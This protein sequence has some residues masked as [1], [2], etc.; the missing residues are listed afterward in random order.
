MRPRMNKRMVALT[1]GTGTIGKR[2]FDAHGDQPLF[3][4]KTRLE[5][6]VKEM[7]AELD[8]VV[9]PFAFLHLAAVT[10][11]QDCEKDPEHAF[12]LNVDGALKWLQAA[13]DSGCERFV[14]V[15]T[16]HVFRPTKQLDWLE[17]SRSPDATTIY[18]RSKAEAEKRLATEAS[19]LG[20]PLLIARVFSVI[21]KGMRKGFLYSEL[22][23]RAQERDFNPM[24]GYKNVRDFIEAEEAAKA[25]YS[26]ASEAELSNEKVRIAHV[27]TGVP[28]T[29]RELA[30]DVFRQ[31]GIGDEPLVAGM[32][33]ETQDDPNYLVSKPT[34]VDA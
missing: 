10:L 5:A 32:F 20:V 9:Q 19:R 30:L 28:R 26:L 34:K 12:R 25:L 6:E 8:Q 17:P 11:V 15:S 13:A 18:G 31:H 21:D 29:V 7:R 3:A 14:F 33:P 16:G 22:E 1:G 4:L 2:L 27:C 24:P 23:R